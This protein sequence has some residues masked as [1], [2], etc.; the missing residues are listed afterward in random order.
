MLWM[1][2]NLVLVT[3]ALLLVGCSSSAPNTEHHSSSSRSG[4]QQPSASTPPAPSTNHGGPSGP[5]PVTHTWQTAARARLPEGLGTANLLGTGPVYPGVYTPPRRWRRETVV[6]MG[7]PGY[8]DIPRPRGWLGVKVLWKIS[9]DYRGP[10]WIRGRETG[11]PGQMRFSEGAEVSNMLRFQ[12][13]GS[14]PSESFVPRAGCYAW[15]IRGRGFHE[16]LVFRAVCM[17]GRDY[18]PCST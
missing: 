2:T 16:V 9:R 8:A 5:C 4:G 12:A 10:V 11:G 18:R 17:A 7:N 6:K 1:R 15:R 13:H 3:A 14:W